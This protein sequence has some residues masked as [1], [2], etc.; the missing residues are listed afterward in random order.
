AGSV[1]AAL[2]TAGYAVVPIGITR[3]G[4][5]VLESGDADALRI[6]PAGELPEV[7]EGGAGLVLAPGGDLVALDPGTVPGELSSVDVVF[8]VLHGPWGEDGTIQGL[9]E[10]AD[11]RYVGSGVLASA[12]GMD[13]HAMKLQLLAQ[14]LPVLP[15][16]VI[17]ARTWESDR[18]RAREAVASL[19]FPV[20][21]KPA[22][23]GSS[24][25]ISRVD[26][27]EELDAAVELARQHDPKV[28]VEA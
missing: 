6:S 7:D 15:Y 27:L 5:W 4:R 21:V 17:S 12:V 13:K 9:L 14:G 16:T 8:P 28:L 20:F 22:R 2:T 24:I 18:A 1:I 11:V 23:G 19:G 3:D 10:L 25:G 26:A